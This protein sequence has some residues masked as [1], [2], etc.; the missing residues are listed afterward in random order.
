MVKGRPL[1][2]DRSP[3]RGCS[4][5]TALA[6]LERSTS[7]PDPEPDQVGQAIAGGEVPKYRPL[8]TALNKKPGDTRIVC[9]DDS[10][11]LA[12][13]AI[14]KGLGFTVRPSEDKRRL[15]KRKAR[16]LKK[17]NKRFAKKCDYDSI[18]DA[19]ND[20]GN[21]DRIVIMPG[22][23]TEP[24]SVAKPENDPAC[25]TCSRTRTTARAPSRIATRRGART[26]RT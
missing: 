9:Q 11:Q 18:Q 16:K 14:R 10:L 23:Y 4:S 24:D 22:F 15:N 3:S 7:W 2:R 8:K 20:S 6:H 13:Q 17:L 1:A 25:W 19:V 12:K 26:T 21:N 5:R